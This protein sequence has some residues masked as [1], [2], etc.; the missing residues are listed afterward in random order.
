MSDDTERQAD[1]DPE[2]TKHADAERLSGEDGDAEA[3]TEL[4]EDPSRNPEDEELRD[5]KG[6]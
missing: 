3:A 1:K 6:G 2:P 4:D 5:V